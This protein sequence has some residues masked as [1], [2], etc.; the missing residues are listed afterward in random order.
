MKFNFV[1]FHWICASYLQWFTAGMAVHNMFSLCFVCTDQWASGQQCMEVR[2][3][4]IPDWKVTRM[5]RKLKIKTTQPIS[6]ILVLFFSENN[7]LS[8]EIKKHLYFRISK[9]RKSTVPIFWDTR[10]SSITQYVY[11]HIAPSY[12]YYYNPF[13]LFFS[14]ICYLSLSLNLHSLYKQGTHSLQTMPVSIAPFLNGRLNNSRNEGYQ[15]LLNLQRVFISAF[16][17]SKNIV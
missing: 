10:Y 15:V 4:I 8:D 13:L 11:I 9:Q 7:V 17:V 1:K 6:M 12:V 14:C 16:N 2:K 3:A 5:K